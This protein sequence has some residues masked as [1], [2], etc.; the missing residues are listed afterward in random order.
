MKKIA[1]ITAVCMVVSIFAFALPIYAEENYSEQYDK[2]P[3]DMLASYLSGALDSE[4]SYSSNLFEYDNFLEAYYDNLT[5]NYGVNYKN[6]CGY[7]ALGMLLS[8]YDTFLND[9]IIPEQYDI[10]SVGTET[11]MVGRRNSPGILR[12]IIENQYDSSDNLLEGLSA[13]EYYSIIQSMSNFSLHAKLITIGA[14]MGYYHFD[15]DLAPAIT[16]LAQRIE[17]LECFLNDISLMSSSEYEIQF[18]FAGMAEGYTSTN[19]RADTINMIQSGRPVLLGVGVPGENIGHAVIAY[20][21]DAENNIVYCHLGFGANETHVPLD[22]TIFTEYR[23][24]M[25]INFD[26]DDLP[27]FNYGVITLT[28]NIPST[29]YYSYDDCSIF[30]YADDSDNLKHNS[31]LRYYSSAEHVEKCSCGYINNLF[32][33]NLSYSYHTPTQH[34]KNCYDC[35]YF[36]PETHSYTSVLASTLASGHQ[37][38][39]VCGQTITEAH[40]KSYRRPYNRDEHYVYCECGYLIETEYHTMVIGW[41][42]GTSTCRGCGYIRDDNGMGE[43]IMGTDTE[44]EV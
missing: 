29:E 13:T 6:S 21:Y 12:D 2:L 27:G 8:Y 23:T 11:D 14:S 34:Y 10:S 39:C 40:Y 22:L 26:M 15:N 20:D 7:I 18:A 5:Y 43:V 32:P 36:G 42:P 17:I 25:V 31:A 24:A 41:K 16:S 37:R 30:T 35:N 28:N 3:P 33:H 1:L 4:T 44:G 38:A 9:D 19:L